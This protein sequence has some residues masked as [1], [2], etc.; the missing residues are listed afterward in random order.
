MFFLS[1]GFVLAGSK[2]LDSLDNRGRG[3]CE[4]TLRA[5]I[6]KSG[7]KDDKNGFS[8]RRLILPSALLASGS[9]GLYIEGVKS[10]NTGVRDR[11]NLLRGESYFR[12]D[13]YLQY[14]PVASVLGL[15]FLGAKAKHSF[16]ER[17][18]ITVS[19][20]AALGITVNS[21]KYTICENRPD[22]SR[23]NS[24]PS[25]HTATAFMGAE[26]IRI[27]YGTGY[28]IG[29]YAVAGLVGVLRIYNNRHWLTDVIAGAGAGILSARIGYWMLPLNRRLFGLD[30]KSLSPVLAACPSYDPVSG[31]YG[32][33]LALNF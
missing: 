14:L 26:L 17:L 20:Y 12:A 27:E 30:K 4:D 28:G 31:S 32:A 2:G 25:G 1:S 15:D 10:F 16:A 18:I 3:A 21:L 9:T 24:F 29:A 23:A 8:Y 11:A 5:K 13:D 19:S 22:G 7:I 33:A 6:L